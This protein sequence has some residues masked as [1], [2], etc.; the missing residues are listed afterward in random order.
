MRNWTI[1]NLFAHPVS[2]PL[3]LVGFRRASGWI[4]DRTVPVHEPG[5]GRG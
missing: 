4:H 1:H 3:W 2:E 5:T